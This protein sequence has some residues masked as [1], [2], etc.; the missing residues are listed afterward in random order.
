MKA[1]TDIHQSKKLAEILSPETADMRS[2][3]N[4]PCWSLAALLNF[5]PPYLFELEIRQISSGDSLIDV[6]FEMIIKLHKQK[7]L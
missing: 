7:L 1:F 5:I 6:A 4:E 2:N 3:D